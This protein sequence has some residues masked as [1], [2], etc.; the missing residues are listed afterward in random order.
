MAADGN[1]QNP[2]GSGWLPIDLVS[3]AQSNLLATLPIDPRNTEDHY[4]A[5]STEPVDGEFSLFAAMES[6][7]YTSLAGADGG[8]NGTLFETKPATPMAPVVIP[9]TSMAFGAE[10]SYN[11]GAT[12]YGDIVRLDDTHVAVAYRDSANSGF[13]TASIGTISGNT[14]TYGP[15]YIFNNAAVGTVHAAAIDATHFVVSYV[16]NG[17]GARGTAIIGTVTGNTISFGAEYVYNAQ[18]T[19]DPSVAVLDPTHIVFSFEDQNGYGTAMIGVVSG[20]N[21]LSFG[22][23]YVYN[24]STTQY[25]AVA[26]LDATHFVTTYRDYATGNLGTARVGVVTGNTIAYGAEY[27]FRNAAVMETAVTPIDATHLIVVYTDG[28]GNAVH[29]TVSGNAIA[30]DTAQSFNGSTNYIKAAAL[31]NERFAVVYQDNANG[32]QGTAII[33][34]VSGGAIAFGSEY[35]F[36][37]GQTSFLGLEKIDPTHFI[38]S[39]HDIGAGQ[40]NSVIGYSE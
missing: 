29:G 19:Y 30:F 14:V 25:V 38:N 23:E 33:G 39:Y 26:A 5:Y 40:G 7:K 34:T 20:G 32:Q 18:G 12:S 8:T 16:D 22:A 17:N 24:T 9:W 2:N 3:A 35:V 6:T 21:V 4:Y 37:G 28:S 10:S 27:V 11:I 31:D 13:G 1:L 15:E 36:N